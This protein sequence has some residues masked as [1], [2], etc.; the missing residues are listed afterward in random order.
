MRKM[1]RERVEESGKFENLN[2]QAFKRTD[3]IDIVSHFDTNECVDNLLY[4]ILIQT[5]FIFF[6]PHYLKSCC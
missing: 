6:C 4:H 1:D 2:K 3:C 5:F